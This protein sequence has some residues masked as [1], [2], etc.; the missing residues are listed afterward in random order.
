MPFPFSFFALGIYG[1]EE[2]GFCLSRLGP[3]IKSLPYNMVIRYMKAVA[4]HDQLTCI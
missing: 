4:P 2:S 1:K 3:T